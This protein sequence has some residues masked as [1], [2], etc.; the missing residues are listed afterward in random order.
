MPELCYP[1]HFA[2]DLI[3]AMVEVMGEYGLNET[4]GV[5]HVARP[6]D[7]SLKRAYP[8]TALGQINSALNTVY[9]E[10]GGR[11]MALRTGRAWF[12]NGMRGFGAMVGVGDPAFR[13]LTISNRCRVALIAQVEIFSRFS[14]QTTLFEETAGDFRIVVEHSPFAAGLQEERPVCHVLVGLFQECLRWASNG[15]DYLVRETHCTAAGGDTCT[16]VIQK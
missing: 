6:A 3:S 11:G 16:F 7:T 13:V 8:F 15:R 5:H 9:G 2:A 10:R 14:D 1:N 12:S 4:L